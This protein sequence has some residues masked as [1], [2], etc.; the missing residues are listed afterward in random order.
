[1]ARS[2]LCFLSVARSLPPPPPA[3]QRAR[4]SRSTTH[5]H[6]RARRRAPRCSR[7]A[8]H[9]ATECSA[10]ATS[11]SSA[12]RA[13][14]VV[15]V[16]SRARRCGWFD[17]RAVG[18]VEQRD[19]TPCCRRLLAENETGR[20]LRRRGV[21]R[22]VVLSRAAQVPVRR[23]AARVA[24][25]RG[26][27]HRLGRKEP[28]LQRELAGLGHGSVSWSPRLPPPTPSR[29]LSRYGGSTSPAPRRQH[30][31]SGRGHNGPTAIRSTEAQ[32]H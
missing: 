28:F 6:R 11:R 8:R 19:A 4:G 29:G 17:P 10:S 26:L 13:C 27:P 2:L 16:S 18:G 1:M 9:G 32:H 24:R 30:N 7:D 20:A 15:G 12:S 31:H 14:G 5:P 3:R 21:L 22:R 25:P 23:D